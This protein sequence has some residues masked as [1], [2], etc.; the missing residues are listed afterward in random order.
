MA[1]EVIE[2]VPMEIR[3]CVCQRKHHSNPSHSLAVLVQDS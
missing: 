3:H 1:T 2:G